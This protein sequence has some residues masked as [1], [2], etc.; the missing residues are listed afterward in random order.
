MWAV[1]RDQMF[2]EPDGWVWGVFW[3]SLAFICLGMYA[4]YQFLQDGGSIILLIV[5]VMFGLFGL[6]ELLPPE[7]RYVTG[8]FRVVSTVMAIALLALLIFLPD[9]IL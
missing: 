4:N 2:R 3:L 6:A 1:I 7:R 8:L 9:L 5:S